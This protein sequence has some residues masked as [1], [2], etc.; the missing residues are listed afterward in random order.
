VD[1][2]LLA[3]ARA[4]DRHDSGNAPEGRGARYWAPL[5]LVG[6][7]SVRR[8]NGVGRASLDL[9]LL[10]RRAGVRLGE[11][12]RAPCRLRLGHTSSTRIFRPWMRSACLAHPASN[13]AW[14]SASIVARVRQTSTSCSHRLFHCFHS[15]FH[16]R[17][18]RKVRGAHVPFLPARVP[19]WGRIRHGFGR[20]LASQ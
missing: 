1:H 15:P 13:V 19:F 10:V 2:L 20:T 11:W 8:C 7:R 9:R 4:A 3:V 16:S 6:S 17:G 5:G 12:S 14:R 18:L